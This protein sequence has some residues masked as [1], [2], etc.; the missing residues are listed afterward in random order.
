MADAADRTGPNLSV[1]ITWG[2]VKWGPF[3]LRVTHVPVK[4]GKCQYCK[5][6]VRYRNWEH[7]PQKLTM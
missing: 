6:A 5:D 3:K 7:S 1:G 4:A 2:K